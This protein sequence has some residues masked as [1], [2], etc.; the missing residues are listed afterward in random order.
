MKVTM[1][2]LLCLMSLLVHASGG[3]SIQR[4]ETLL[5]RSERFVE[6][7]HDEADSDEGRS[8]DRDG[9]PL[10]RD[11]LEEGG[12]S[13][14][15]LVCGLV[16]IA[17]NGLQ[18]TGWDVP[19][20]RKATVVA[21]ELLADINHPD[22]T[23]YFHTLVG[24]D[25][26]GLESVVLPAMFSHTNLEPEVFES[27]Y[28]SCAHTN[29]YDR[30]APSVAMELL[31]VL[32][33]LPASAREAAKVRVARFLHFSMR[34]VTTS[35][36]WQDEQLAKL[37]PDYSNS[38]ERLEQVR[39]LMGHSARDYE[40]NRAAAQFRRLSAIPANSLIRV[41]WLCGRD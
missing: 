26:H 6:S 40:R 5:C 39:Y 12:W 36:T 10:F 24:D 29:F 31:D 21:V 41:P 4:L 38:V 34:Q 22:V 8:W 27:L 1:I 23:N 20:R 37:I 25:L 19:E 15:Q 30:A 33:R 16:S 28:R 32:G 14:N 17:S 2:L 35:Q 13:T 18:S 11:V 3:W 9:I 7:D